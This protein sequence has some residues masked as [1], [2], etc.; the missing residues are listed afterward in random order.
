MA[1]RLKADPELLRHGGVALRRASSTSFIRASPASWMPPVSCC[2]IP[3]VGDRV[4]AAVVPRPGEPISLEAL[5]QFL[6]ER[7]GRA[8]Q[9]PRP[10]AGGEADPARRRGSRAA[11]ADLAAGVVSRPPASPRRRS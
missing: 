4:F 3:I 8:L 7:G 1:I 9:I 5:H 11:R 2:P 10:A 6:A